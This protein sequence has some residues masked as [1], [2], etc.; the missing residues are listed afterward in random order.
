M[1]DEAP[2]PPEWLEEHRETQ[3]RYQE[4]L[5]PEQWATEAKAALT[6]DA[7][8]DVLRKKYPEWAKAEADAWS[9]AWWTIYPIWPAANSHSQTT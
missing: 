8:M 7:A 1:S 3:R 2:K 9:R 6:N 4:S 5:S